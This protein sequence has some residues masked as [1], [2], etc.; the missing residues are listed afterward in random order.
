MLRLWLLLQQRQDLLLFANFLLKFRAVLVV[1]MQT[2]NFDDQS[3]IPKKTFILSI[4]LPKN[5]KINDKDAAVDRSFVSIS[6]LFV[7]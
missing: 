2:V 6:C 1:T 7:E 3:L 4:L 5:M